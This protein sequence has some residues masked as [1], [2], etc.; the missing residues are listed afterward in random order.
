MKIKIQDLE[1]IAGVDN[2]STDDETIDLYSRDISSLP[3]LAYQIIQRNFD[4]VV[5]PESVKSL[6]EIVRFLKTNEVSMV[7]RGNGTSGWGGI[8]PSK[9]GV[10]LCMTQMSDMIH[11]DEYQTRI[12]VEAGITWRE[13]LMFIERLGL[14]LPVYPS[15]AAAA[16]VGGFIASGGLGIGSAM[17]GN[18]MTQVLGI[19]VVLANGLLVRIGE[20]VLG[21]KDDLQEEA[22]VGNVWM[23]TQLDELSSDGDANPL[24][25]FLGTYGAFGII[26]RVTL[27]AIPKLM[28]HSFACSFD[29]I[30]D[31]IQAATA[32]L[33][34][35]TPYHLRYQTDSYTSKLTTLTGL[36]NEEGKHILSG[37]FMGTVYLIE[38]NVEILNKIVEQQLGTKLSDIRAKFHWAER[39]F[40][41]RI[42]R[43]GP[44]LVPA[45]LMVPNNKLPALFEETR[46]KL[47]NSK[48]AIEGTFGSDGESSFLVWILD[49]ERKTLSY[50]FGWHR[51]F[52]ISSLAKKFDG[53]PYA[54]G[55]WNVSS[56]NEFYG[57]KHYR[58]LKKFKKRVDP[59]NI[60]NPL[61]VFGGRVEAAKESLV[62]GFFGGLTA[63]LTLSIIVPNI[64]S[65]NWLNEILWSQSLPI[66]LG[67]IVGL[68]GGAIG[69]L[70]IKSLSI[71]K[72]LRFGIPLLRLL[73]KVFIRK[74]KEA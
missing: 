46:S 71:Q 62:F 35:A 15:S 34:E 65:L 2:V 69:L 4:I 9:G 42:K 13:L 73:A 33:D 51:S 17:H 48:Y 72:A 55:L 54:I 37:A 26:T 30:S 38:D 28:M 39:M 63:A 31:L 40:P 41:L 19:E 61:K 56:A 66:P 8:L 24:D 70:F 12:T 29:N 16:T 14:T 64:L 50:T 22:N 44:S 7:P 49:D 21:P 11:I 32:L 58:F 27:K 47:K 18:I 1:D 52:D 25:I 57:K 36:V 53:K 23:K 3:K 43:L 67:L 60:L 59:Q 6:I 45:E 5:Q 10:S 20:L 68:V 74:Q